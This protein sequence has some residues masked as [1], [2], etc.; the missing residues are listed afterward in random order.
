MVYYALLLDR[1][2]LSRLSMLDL[3]TY[4]AWCMT[5][6]PIALYGLITWRVSSWYRTPHVGGSR[7]DL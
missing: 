4:T 2:D 1:R 3:L 6:Y 5:N 7:N